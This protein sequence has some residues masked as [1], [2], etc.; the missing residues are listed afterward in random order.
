PRSRRFDLGRHRGEASQSLAGPAIAPWNGTVLDDEPT[1][2]FV[3]PANVGIQSLGKARL[4]ARFRGHDRRRFTADL[5][6]S[7]SASLISGRSREKPASPF[8]PPALREWTLGCQTPKLLRW[9]GPLAPRALRRERKRARR[10]SKGE[11]AG[12]APSG[13]APTPTNSC[14]PRSKWPC[15]GLKSRRR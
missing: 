9:N 6:L 10:S 5:S 15:A 4:D 7:G 3:I 12:P 8:S 14:A 1:R 13:S 11:L 2:P